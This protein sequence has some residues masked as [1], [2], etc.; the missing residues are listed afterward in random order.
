M[1]IH[2]LPARQ[3]YLAALLVCVLAGHSIA[4]QVKL[5]LENG[6]VIVGELVTEADDTVKVELADGS[7]F[8]V[9]RSYVKSLERLGAGE[10]GGEDDAPDPGRTEPTGPGSDAD[11]VLEVPDDPERDCTFCNGY[12]QRPCWLCGGKG[13]Y[14]IGGVPEP[15]NLCKKGKVKCEACRGTGAMPDLYKYLPCPGCDF[16]VEHS[17]AP[18]LWACP[19]CHGIGKM[20]I[21]NEPKPRKCAVC[22]GAGGFACIVCQGKTRLDR[23]YKVGSKRDAKGWLERCETGI[24]TIDSVPEILNAESLEARDLI[25]AGRSI[26]ELQAMGKMLAQHLEMAEN[27]EKR[28][29]EGSAEMSAYFK[30][31]AAFSV[32]R[33]LKTERLLLEQE[34][35][36]VH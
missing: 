35:S 29:I 33:Y 2:L 36:F 24:A 34:K 18:G 26:R 13:G 11:L 9:P 27:L 21:A 32:K 5:V 10:D 17:V 8:E 7:P 23:L 6:D 20:K 22:N 3:G 16:D 19:L 31:I 30:R 25:A 12:K 28:N 1:H 14:E 15:C 4:E